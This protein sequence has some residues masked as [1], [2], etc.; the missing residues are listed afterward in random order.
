MARGLLRSVQEERTER[1]E[2]TWK[3]KRLSLGA[4]WRYNS[5]NSKDADNDNRD[6]YNNSNSRKN[7]NINYNKDGKAEYGGQW[8]VGEEK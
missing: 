7:N 1:E 6:N 3:K 2:G 5:N 4:K 8:T